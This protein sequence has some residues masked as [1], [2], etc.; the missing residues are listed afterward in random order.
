MT[1]I[2]YD[3]GRVTAI[4]P[5][6]TYFDQTWFSEAVQAVVRACR[7]CT[8]DMAVGSSMGGVLMNP[9]VT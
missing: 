1:R 8:A 9:P 5:L 6:F 7:A 4:S 3:H 2:L